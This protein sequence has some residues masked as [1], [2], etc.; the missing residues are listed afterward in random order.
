MNKTKNYDF[1]VIVPVFNEEDNISRLTAALSAY[2]SA[3]VLRTCVLFV[4]DGSKD[5]SLEKIKAVCCETNGFY[6]L[7]LGRNSGLS[8]ALK[9]GIDVAES[10]YV[11]YI[12]ADLQTSPDDFN[13]LLSHIDGNGL[14]T[15]I[16]MGR[17]DTVFKRLQ[18]RVA[19]SFRRF[20]THDGMTDTGC[21][22]KV[23]R[24]E[25]A[26]RVP[27]FNGMHRFLPALFLMMGQ[28]VEQIPVHSFPRMA[29]VSKYN[30]WNRL[31]S[32]FADCFA[33]RW[34]RK[35][36]ISYNVAESD[37]ACADR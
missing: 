16:R 33:Y 10:Q 13:L 15:G 21:P 12:D 31:L 28:N 20:M 7:A 8:T 1:T 11:G 25:W 26:K 30:L 29:G 14:V 24:T 22:L 23:M 18:S 9:A 2:M 27:F 35:R 3:A 36:Y 37:I 6:F 34:M 17:K 32:P 19:N 5:G 4:D